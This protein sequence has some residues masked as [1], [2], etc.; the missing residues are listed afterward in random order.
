MSR[1]HTRWPGFVMAPEALIKLHHEGLTQG[2]G[3]GRGR[4]WS[5]DNPKK[6]VGSGR[7]PSVLR[8]LALCGN[9]AILTV[10]STAL[11]RLAWED[12]PAGAPGEQAM[13]S[14]LGIHTLWASLLLAAL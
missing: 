14:T 11:R 4:G 5:L 9:S 8:A 13:P 1:N 12:R 7:K 10:Q 2:W 6:E 3:V